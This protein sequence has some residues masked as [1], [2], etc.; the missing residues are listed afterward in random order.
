[1]ER[2][3][4]GDEGAFSDLFDELEP[5]LRRIVLA[6]TSNEAF[7]DDVIQH[8]F[9]QI[10]RCRQHY[11]RGAAVVP[12]SCA[13]ARN[14]VRD[15]A[16]HWAIESQAMEGYRVPAGSPELPPDE[17]VDNRMS[18]RRLEGALADLPDHLREAFVMVALEELSIVEASQ[19]LGITPTNTKQRV[20]RAREMLRALVAG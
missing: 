12:W 3:A 2:Y 4:D 16:R 8:T 19:V 20:H 5:R 17:A 10:V 9:Q 15:R 13:I 11:A 14:F 18:E 6:L 7:V 1:M